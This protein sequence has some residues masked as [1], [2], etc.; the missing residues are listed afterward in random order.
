MVRQRSGVIM[1]IAVLVLLLSAGVTSAAAQYANDLDR[2]LAVEQYHLGLEKMKA[3][4]FEQAAAAFIRAIRHDKNQP[5]AYYALGQA[6]AARQ[7]WDDA[8]QA[9]AGGISALR[10]AGRYAPEQYGVVDNRTDVAFREART[11]GNRSADP[12]NALGRSA[13]A[14]S[15]SDRI[16]NTGLQQGRSFEADFSL[17]I[18]TA[19][20]HAGKL[21]EAEN[22][23]RYAVSLHPELGEAWNNL[24]ALY[25]QTG[26][27]APALEALRAAQKAGHQVDAALVK[28]I[29][30]MK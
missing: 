18:G 27:K 14:V 4:A 11:V 17:A 16:R 22:E 29:N 12:S 5:L 6:Y 13:S 20:F 2:R 25:A 21:L 28:T 26:H 3:G 23:W 9:Y 15:V 10:A 19:F 7:R 8:I 1:V 30:D 24:A